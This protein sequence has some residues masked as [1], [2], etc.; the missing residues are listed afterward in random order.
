[1]TL[2]HPNILQFLG[3]NTMDDR[4]F[5]VMPL[6]PY[7]AREFLRARPDFEPLH[8]LR[9]ISL[10]LEYLHSRKICHGDLKGINVLVE[11]FGRA[12]LCDFGLARIKADITSRTRALSDTVVSGSRNW[13]APELLSGSLPRTPSD[14]YAFGM[15]LYEVYTGEIP[16]STI[17][18]ADFIELVF[19][20]GVR[21]DRPEEDECPRMNDGI[22]DLAE[23]C[24][25]KDPKARPTARQIH[26]TIELLMMSLLTV[27]PVESKMVSGNVLPN[28]NTTP[29]LRTLI[30][31]PSSP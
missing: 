28:K 23:R 26:D 10:G 14:I 17:P 29:H 5:V 6:L 3:A 15:T 31:A 22:W 30:L 16:M 11:E 7:N 25:N 21:P 1:M 20:F 12:L 4:P 8:I 9:D 27:T 2:R 24:W 18:Y 19:R 13:M